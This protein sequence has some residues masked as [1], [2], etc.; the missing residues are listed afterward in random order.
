MKYCP[1][2]ARPGPHAAGVYLLRHLGGRRSKTRAFVH[3]AGNSMHELD[4]AVT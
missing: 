4:R 1:A 3:G 2:A